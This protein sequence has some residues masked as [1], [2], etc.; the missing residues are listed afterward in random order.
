[1]IRLLRSL[2]GL[3]GVTGNRTV[4]GSPESPESK[5]LPYI[6][7]STRRLQL[8]F[9]LYNR[10]KNTP[11]GQQVKA[12]YEKT[13][14]IHTY[15]AG[16]N[17]VH[18]LEVFH[19]QHTDH[20]LSTFTAIINVHQQQHKAPAPAAPP[21]P[22]RPAGKPEIIGRTLVI[23]PFRRDRKEVKAARMQ[24]RET[25]QQ[26]FVDIADTKTEIPKLAEPEIAINTYSKIVY[27]REDISDGLTTNEIGFTSTP[28]EKQTFA[29]H[30]AARLGLEHV[31][32][33]GNA[34]VYIQTHTSAHSPEM[35]PVIHWNGSPYVLSLEDYRLF[36]V[37]T[38]RKSR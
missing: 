17:R 15:L 14:R 22:Q 13:Q 26:V 23:G 31:T 8:L 7:E 9:E 38:F 27:L 2:F 33:V 24:N 30:I 36:P 4:V 37:R 29:N 16:R 28:E 11:H 25:S 20:F 32:Y 12:V 34:L 5:H 3:K 18:E 10:Y 6:E 35:V 19:L 1:M 21:P